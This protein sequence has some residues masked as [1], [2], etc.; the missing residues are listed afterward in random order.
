M[1]S[2]QLA[3]HQLGG[4]AAMADPSAEPWYQDGLRFECT[5]CGNCCTGS[6]GAVWFTAEEGREM[7]AVMGLSEAEFHKTY[8]RQIHGNWSL[9]EQKGPGGM[10]CVFLTWDGQGRSGCG[11]YAAR[12]QQ[13][14]TWPFWKENLESPAT[15]DEAKRRTPCPGMDSGPLVTIDE[16]VARLDDP[17]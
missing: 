15:W 16:I 12:P 4:T 9:R 3:Q 8:A 14:R 6:P 1:T 11:L 10:D 7:A 2:R 17:G 13:C 5:R